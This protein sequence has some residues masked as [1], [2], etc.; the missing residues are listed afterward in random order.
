MREIQTKARFAARVLLA[1]VIILAG[2]AAM[3]A[4]VGAAGIGAT[5][6]L[7]ASDY[8]A[9]SWQRYVF[10]ALLL[11]ES[12]LGIKALLELLSSKTQPRIGRL[13]PGDFNRYFSR[14]LQLLFVVVGILA[15]TEAVLT[16]DNHVRKEAVVVA[17]LFSVGVIAEERELR[18][19]TVA[20]G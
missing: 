2:L 1:A 9:S 16:S 19:A 10:C 5:L 17:V 15:I 13:F 7:S 4:L 18:R 6:I 12:G 8:H 20:A 14:G 11:I 3:G